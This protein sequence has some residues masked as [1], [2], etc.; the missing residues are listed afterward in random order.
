MLL[1]SIG[2]SSRKQFGNSLPLGKRCG[3]GS[4]R[5]LD[6]W[7]GAPDHRRREEPLRSVKFNQNSRKR[8][9]KRSFK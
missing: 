7:R 6:A 3:A 8:K 4:G 5:P 1:I 9:E 2:N